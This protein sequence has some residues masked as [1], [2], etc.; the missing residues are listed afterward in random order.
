LRFDLKTHESLLLLAGVLGL[1]EQEA[2][3][4]LF[5]LEPSSVLSGGFVSLALASIGLAGLR[6]LLSGRRN[7][8]G[9][10]GDDST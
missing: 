3:R 1:I 5:D 8:N 2:A 4:L 6:G 7:G 9:D 10:R